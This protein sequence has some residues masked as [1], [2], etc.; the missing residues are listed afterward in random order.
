MLD[1]RENSAGNLTPR[2]H[3]VHNDIKWLSTHVTDMEKTNA[4]IAHDLMVDL[5]EWMQ[6]CES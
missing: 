4:T 2:S 3:K 6:A 1:S 5:T